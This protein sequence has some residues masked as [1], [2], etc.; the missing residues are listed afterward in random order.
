MNLT[1][2]NNAAGVR[3]YLNGLVTVAESGQTAISRDVNVLIL[4]DSQ[5]VTDV[6]NTTVILNNGAADLNSGAGLKLI[7]ELGIF[8]SDPLH[9]LG[10]YYSFP[11]G[12]YHTG[13]TNNGLTVWAIRN[14]A[15]SA[16]ALVIESIELT[17]MFDAASP[18]AAKTDFYELITFSTATPSGGTSFNPNK[19]AKIAPTSNVDARF[20]QAGL[21]MTSVVFDPQM[22]VIGCPVARGASTRFEKKRTCLKLAPG[23]G[24]AIR[25]FGVDAS[26][27][28]G[29]TGEIVGSFR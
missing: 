6:G 8:A 1:I 26:I 19:M 12:I 22:A 18:L 10:L 3:S 4:T 5:F 14:S 29:L 11:V 17:A 28:Q 16:F 23:E 24:L 27:G 9:T 15:G 2:K 20:S 25:V 21:T 13:T 7:S